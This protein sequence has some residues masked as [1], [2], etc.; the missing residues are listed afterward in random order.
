M[1]LTD[2]REKVAQAPSRGTRLATLS[3]TK[4]AFGPPTRPGLELRLEKTQN[5]VS[6]NVPDV[7]E[8]LRASCNGI[9]IVMAKS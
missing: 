3:F 6:T 5:L 2:R 8:S 7:I 9:G 1:I 4:S